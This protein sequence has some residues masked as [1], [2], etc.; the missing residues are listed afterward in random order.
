MSDGAKP[1]G[2]EVMIRLTLEELDEM[3]HAVAARARMTGSGTVNHD[4]CREILRK[5]AESAARNEGNGAEPKV[6]GI[7]TK[8]HKGW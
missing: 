7:D 4:R 6:A 8:E 1:K 3:R 5:L 2:G